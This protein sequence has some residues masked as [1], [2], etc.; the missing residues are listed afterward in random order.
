MIRLIV[1]STF[2]IQ[3]EYAE[4][5]NIKVVRLKM[6]LD[7][8]VFD[9]GFED[10]WLPFYEKMKA[11]KSFPT[12][13]QPSPQDFIDAIEEV[14]T[15]DPNAEI[16]VLTIS[17]ALSGTIN[18][19][20]IAV[21]SFEGKKIKAIDSRQ[22]TTCGRLMTEEIIEAI[23]HGKSYEEILELISVLQKKLQ[24]DFIPDSMDALKRGGRIGSLSAA[25]ASILKIKPIFR[26][27]DGK[28]TVI[29][30][31]LGF[32]KAINDIVSEVPEKL[33]K[34]Y[35]CYIHDNSNIQKIIEKIKSILK[36]QEIET[37]NIEPVFGVHVG[38]GSVGIA[39]LEQY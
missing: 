34:L 29:K 20:N 39:S 3:R 5:H 27:S 37:V 14:Y 8:E 7:G 6:I 17:N 25:F 4:K 13:S 33:K 22:A 24:I 21:N 18:S 10:T 11:S 31:V 30:K 19:A 38:I 1:D 28:I 12:T 9:E 15:E 16:I 35:V 2:G 23:E 36:I 26:F 32:Q